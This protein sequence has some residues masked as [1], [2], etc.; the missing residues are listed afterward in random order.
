[1][2]RFSS[3]LNCENIEMTEDCLV[4]IFKFNLVELISLSNKLKTM[5]M[6]SF[7]EY[8]MSKYTIPDQLECYFHHFTSTLNVNSFEYGL[9]TLN[10]VYIQLL[11][12]LYNYLKDIISI[13][14]WEDV[15]RKVCS[16]NLSR[17]R[18]TAFSRIN[19]K[20]HGPYGFL[21]KEFGLRKRSDVYYLESSEYIEDIFRNTNFIFKGLIDEAKIREIY[22]ENK[23]Q[24]V[25]TF[26]RVLNNPNEIVKWLACAFQYVYYKKNTSDINCCNEAYDNQ[27]IDIVRDDIKYI[28]II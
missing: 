23:K 2:N 19:D 15:R 24:V 1:M 8:L 17:D 21:I 25:V 28:Q 18:T 7:K 20:K 9:L 27:G 13:T 5:D 12:D 26:S 10:K 14:E 6:N 16:P 3:I 4:E 22:N 11:N